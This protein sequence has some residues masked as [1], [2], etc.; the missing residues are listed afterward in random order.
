[1]VFVIGEKDILTGDSK[2]SRSGLFHI[3]YEWNCKCLKE[4]SG[5]FLNLPTAHQTQD[6]ECLDLI[7]TFSSKQKLQQALKCLSA[8]FCLVKG[9]T[10]NNCD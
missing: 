3:F 7:N 6:I 4:T 5:T 2:R 10:H 8:C 9:N 1:M